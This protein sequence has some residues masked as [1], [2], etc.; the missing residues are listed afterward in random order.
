ML[1]DVI[2]KVDE[3][4]MMQKYL[5]CECT[6]EVLVLL[7]VEQSEAAGAKEDAKEKQSGPK[8]GQRT[9]AF[10]GAKRCP[11]SFGTSCNYQ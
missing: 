8:G 9:R 6:V 1:F 4:R 7:E 3:R 10:F 11:K 2:C 5:E